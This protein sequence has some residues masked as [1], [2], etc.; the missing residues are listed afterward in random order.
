[1]A[2]ANKVVLIT[3][4]NRGIG[5]ETARQLGQLGQQGIT[6][7]VTGRTG[8]EAADAAHKLQEEGLPAGS[9]TLDVTKADDRSRPPYRVP[10][11]QVRHFG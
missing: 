9:I 1:M 11:R 6:V 10:L 5:F 3:G 2:H 7:V 4:S 8:K